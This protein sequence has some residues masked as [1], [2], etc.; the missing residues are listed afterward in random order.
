MELAIPQ[1]GGAKKHGRERREKIRIA[2]SG[3][4][5]AHVG[6]AQLLVIAERSDGDP[7]YWPEH[8]A[9]KEWVKIETF[10]EAFW[11]AIDFH[12][13][14]CG[15]DL[16]LNMLHQSFDLARTAARGYQRYDASRR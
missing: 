6:V 13:D 12:A 5:A 14:A 2:R 16:D 7:Y 11:R 1:R 9:A 3:R 10:L 15:N 4:A 8:M